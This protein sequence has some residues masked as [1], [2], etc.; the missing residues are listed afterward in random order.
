M[1][2]NPKV[3]IGVVTAQAKDYCVKPFIEQLKT[4][5]YDNY[6]TFVVDNSIDENHKE[7]FEKEGIE[8]EHIT[9]LKGNGNFKRA[10]VLLTEC[11][12]RVRE[13]FLASDCEYLFILESD[14]FI[15]RDFI[16]WALSHQ[17]PVYTVTY[18]I[19]VERYKT[20]SMCVQYLHVL[21]HLGI[22]KAVSNSLMLPPDITIPSECR[23]IL[24]FR[25]GDN[26]ML[27]HTGVGCTLIHKDVMKKI[28][29]RVDRNNDIATGNMTFSDTF[30]FND[31]HANKYET[32]LDNRLLVN[33]VKNW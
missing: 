11:Q 12:N 15:N 17:A 4:F 2:R 9:R 21:R 20:P 1:S 5:R 7:I 26:M 31:L 29:F 10:N 25:I 19:K 16:A 14:C 33:H 6:I 24:D 28:M 32:L 13:K 3:M 18:P 8:A 22:N 23:N 27:T 30:F